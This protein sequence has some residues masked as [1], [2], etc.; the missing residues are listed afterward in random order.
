MRSCGRADCVAP[1]DRPRATV[2]K[3]RGGVRLA[4]CNARAAGLG[5]RPGLPLAD[6]R[7]RIPELAAITADRPADA[8]FLETLA[9][10]C[11][12]YTPSFAPDPPSGLLLDITGCAHLFGGEASLKAHAE[13][14]FA[15][16]GL[17]T[18]AAIAGTPE[19]ARALV[20]CGWHGI[21]APE[22]EEDIVRQLPVSALNGTDAETL[23]AL[24][25]AGLKTLGA[26]AERPTSAL[27]ARFGQNFVTE[28]LRTLGRETAGIIPLRPAPPIVVARTFAEPLLQAEA[29]EEV[30]ALLLGEAAHL[31]EE[32]GEGGR[33]FEASFF[34]TDGAV[35]RLAVETGR[36]ARDVPSLRRLY[37]ERIATL[38]DPIDPGFGFD[39]VRL[40][41]LASERMTPDEP[42]FGENAGDG[43]ALDDLLDHLIVRFG[44]SRVLSFQP[45]DSHDPRRESLLGSV[46]EKVDAARAAWPPLM[47]DAP[48]LRPIEMF[49]RPQPIDVMAEVPDGPPIR[50]RW[51][52]VV[53]RV[54]H[55]EGP[56][57][58]APEWWLRPT[59]DPSR[60]YY[61]VEDEEGGR[62]W[63]FREGF[64]AEAAP[65]RWYLHGIFA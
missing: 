33:A 12:R 59:T 39:V 62:F 45:R 54:L 43:R 8:A 22:T 28:L 37:R 14:A 20:T 48:P 23:T 18:R 3:V 40:A 19:A 4:A 58:I 2:E 51:R 25:R 13:R 26:L 36:A 17:T 52:R 65:P 9:A 15:H 60:D 56:E 7:A 42:L 50:F 21:T 61:R 34:R 41:V 49:S 31:L 27:A 29:L 16:L 10:A 57:R 6:A 32:R 63:I 47:P 11:E 24:R 38:A 30:L 53:H 46:S 1:D 44:R 35:R 64:Y 55:A 5:L